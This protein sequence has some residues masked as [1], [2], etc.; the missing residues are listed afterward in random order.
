MV[1]TIGLAAFPFTKTQAAWLGLALL[2]GI[3][4]TAAATVANLFV[5]EA[6]PQPEWDKRIGWLQ[7]FYGGGQV[8]GLLLA[9]VLSQT[10]LQTGLLVASGLTLM[11][12]LLSWLTTETPS[13]RAVPQP[14][15]LH[16]GRHSEWMV[17]SP[18]H[19]YH[20]PSFDTLRKMGS[21][22]RSPFTLFLT[23]WSLPFAGSAA[24]FSLYPILM[25]HVYGVA[26]GLSSVGFA[27]AAGLG[28]TLYSPAG[29]WSDRF[30]P[31]HVMQAALSIRLLA[32]LSL[33][34]LGVSHFGQVWLALT[35]FLFIV[36]AWSLLS[37][38]G[39]ALTAQLS[40]VG[41]GEGMGIF[42]A[43]TALAGV[44]GAALGGW[45]A[46]GWGYN[47]ALVLAIGGVGLGLV[48]TIVRQPAHLKDQNP[49]SFD[50][51]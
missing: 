20:H 33:W 42:N 5:V 41:Q 40:P 30:G 49:K 34:A 19:L 31:A 7:T 16:P 26:P 10:N 15:L 18:Q 36:L 24:F 12:A 39:T 9:G 47:G 25:L 14:V 37:V 3:G 22:L 45:I 32:F 35:G 4:A 11:A 51:N 27:V 50:K 21:R 38:S 17:G 2:Q 13:T 46:E 43:V 29:G 23:V 1:S 6:H 28:L 44:I 8:G 48:L